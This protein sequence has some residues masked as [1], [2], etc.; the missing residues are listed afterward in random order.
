RAIAEFDPVRRAGYQFKIIG[1]L[2]RSNIGVGIKSKSWHCA[3]DEV[4]RVED[5]GMMFTR[6]VFVL[7]VLAS[8]RDAVSSA[9]VPETQL[10]LS[11]VLFRHGARTTYRFY[12][13]DP[14]RNSTFYP[15]GL[16][17]LTNEGKMGEYKLGKYLK[18]EYRNF[19]GD[20][21][22]KELIEMRS[23]D[24][25]R[26]KM[27]AQLVL[28]GMW[29]P[30]EEQKWHPRLN[31][32][33]IPVYFKQK[34][35]EDLLGPTIC[36]YRIYTLKHQPKI[37]EVQRKFIEPYRNTFEYI[38]HHSGFKVG[39]PWDALEFYFIVSTETEMNLEL[40]D[41]TKE[42]FPFPLTNISAHVYEYWNYDE[43]VRR[44]NVGYLIKKIVEDSMQ[45]IQ[46]RL[47][48]E[49]RKMFLY[50]GHESTLGYT[51]NALRLAEPHIPPYGSAVLID[52]RKDDKNNYYIQIRYENDLNKPP[53]TLT[54][55]NC[56]TLCPIK[57]FISIYESLIPKTDLKKACDSER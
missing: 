23:T 35:E 42:I 47:K 37:S 55:P 38:Q 1:A 41:W 27:S 44:I 22:F 31:W 7:S 3:I 29:P 48:P 51:L 5:T 52:L 53:K 16:G 21:Y 13:T 19:L 33:P 20:T 11:H 4:L 34:H 43:G 36:K 40:P 8:L 6:L 15:F 45:K 57:K 10:V 14:H 49:T 50:S 2:S 18:D 54:I 46:N 25:T 28:A 17:G 24:T 39:N 12:P 32:Q 30:N 9:K 26:T 56:G